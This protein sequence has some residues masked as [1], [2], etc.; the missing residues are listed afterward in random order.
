MHNYLDKT[1]EWIL[2]NGLQIVFVIVLMIIS[3]K[4]VKT[5]TEKL[6][7]K[8]V[9]TDSDVEFEKRVNTLRSIITSFFEFLIFI[10][11]SIIILEKLGVNTAPILAAAGVLGVAVGFG[12]KRLVEDIISGFLIIMWDQIRVGDVVQI[13]DKSGYVE[14]VDLKTVVLRDLSGNIHFI[15]NGKI[16]IITNMTKDFSCYVFDIGVAYKENV[17]AVIEILKS[18]DEDMRSNSEF[19]EDILEPIEIFGL[20]KFDESAV[21]IKAR[22]KTKPIK[23]W[24]VGREFN[25]RIKQKFDEHGIEI[26][27]PH[28]TLYVGE[29]Q[30]DKQ[31]LLNL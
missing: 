17:D 18:I 14:K 26:P 5:V 21:I 22:T 13:E 24:A 11:G 28:R 20:D 10:I 16:D 25:R 9:Q 6:I 31:Q 23:Q 12:A 1:V 15:R 3:L 27:F 29:S 4:F 30:K 7:L 2:T 8:I 19:K